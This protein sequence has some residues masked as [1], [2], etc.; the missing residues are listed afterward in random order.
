[1]HCYYCGKE[2]PKGTTWR[3]SIEGLPICDL[4]HDLSADTKNNDKE[5]KTD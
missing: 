3:I 1:M 5:T 4:C 2:A